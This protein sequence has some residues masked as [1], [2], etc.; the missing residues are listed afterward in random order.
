MLRCNGED[1]N[2]KGL[3]TCFMANCRGWSRNTHKPWVPPSFD[4]KPYVK[5]ADCLRSEKSCSR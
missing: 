4:E 5:Q 1:M 2:P 3:L